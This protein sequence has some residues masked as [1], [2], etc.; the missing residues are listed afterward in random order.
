MHASVPTVEDNSEGSVNIAVRKLRG[1]CKTSAKDAEEVSM[2]HRLQRN[3]ASIVDRLYRTVRHI[4][5]AA[6][7]GSQL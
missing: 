3:T 1:V 6:E 5:L 2:H 7:E 4:A